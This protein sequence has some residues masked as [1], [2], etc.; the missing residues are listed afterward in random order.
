MG[1][2]NISLLTA[3]DMD[4]DK[5]IE[6][7][8][9]VSSAYELV[10]RGIYIFEYPTFSE[11]LYF[12]YAP[13]VATPTVVD[14]D[15]DGYLEILL[16]SN[17]PCN[18][19]EVGDTDDCHA[20]VTAIDLRG[21]E[22][23]IREI[24]ADYK[25]T[26]IDVADLD[27]DGTNEIVCTGWSFEND[28]GNLFVLDKDGEYVR[29][30]DNVFEHSI[31]LGGITDLDEDGKME[32]LT[33]SS[34]GEISIYDYLLTLKRKK[35]IEINMGKMTRALI[36]DIDADGD[37]EIIVYSNDS[38]IYV[39]NSNL[40]IEWTESVQGYKDQMYVLITNLYG[41]K[42]DLIVLTDKIHVYSHQQDDTDSPCPLWE[43]TERNLAEKA[44]HHLEMAETSFGT[45]D[46]RAAKQYFELALDIFSQLEDE[47]QTT[48]T[49]GKI[50]ETTHII[51][52]QNVK[53]GTILLVVLDSFL[54][55]FIVYSWITRKR[56]HRSIEGTLLLSLPVLLG[57]F[58]VYDSNS[59][60]YMTVF[61]RYFVPALVLSVVA[62]LRRSILAFVRT[63]RALLGGHKDLLVL[64][65]VRADDS[66]R[67]SVESIE[68]K[69]RPVKES[70][71]VLLAKETR[72]NIIKKTEYM[73][74]EILGRIPS[75][76]LA[77]LYYGM[78]ILQKTGSV[79]YQKF[80]PKEFSDI[81]KAKFLL[82][83]VEDTEIPWELMYSDNFFS[84]KYAISRRIVSTE[85]VTVREKKV[86]GRRA[87][88]ISDPKE[89]L[90]GAGPEC[91]TVYKRLTQKMDTILI[92][93]HKATL[94]EV[95]NLF[96]HGFDII[97]YAGHVDNGLLL[98]DGVMTPE[99]VREY[100]VGTPVVV[101]NG[102]KSEELARAFLLGGAMAY[103]G[104][105][106]PV[107]DE[108]AADI[109]ADFYELCLQYQIGE[110][111]RRAR[112]YHVDKHLVWASLIMYGDPTLKL[113]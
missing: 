55:L 12:P 76:D 9:V 6:V 91:D 106:H 113:L 24:G 38:R 105:I 36:N 112:E 64:S 69:F 82:L 94:Q 92:K 51:F 32:I 16:G 41:C 97:H 87:L 78:E 89:N 54:C 59:Q 85:S 14:L 57:L 22:L 23:W 30:E 39:L 100:I 95:A 102:C 77:F 47:A 25:R 81:L 60:Q 13:I 68:E 40:D 27:G 52:R 84:L 96:G 107:H 1:V 104:T 53:T 21:R 26:R 72:E 18:G 7:I 83:E 103:I 73:M 70:R 8:C 98:S 45:G 43:I 11:E 74:V 80:I 10:P 48:Y 109:A 111:L 110:A 29:G 44:A 31:L 35:Q 90:P 4:N 46:Y 101:V 75:G 42:N 2:I 49:S 20:Y 50:A 3:F 65:I 5:K 34:E 79:I 15:G 37:K 28:W 56:W 86:S 71:K 66:Y 63:I 58:Q 99:E 17:A 67:V 19:K 93:G 61:V 33:F 108:S 88:I 62:L